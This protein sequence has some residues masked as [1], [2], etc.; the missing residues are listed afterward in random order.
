MEESVGYKKFWYI[1]M[2]L[3]PHDKQIIL[4]TI[5][6]GN[7]LNLSQLKLTLSKT[8]HSDLKIHSFL[9]SDESKRFNFLLSMKLV[10]LLLS[11]SSNNLKKMIIWLVA[12]ELNQ[13]QSKK[14]RDV[15]YIKLK[16]YA[17]SLVAYPEDKRIS[18]FLILLTKKSKS[19][20]H[21]LQNETL[22]DKDLFIL[23]IFLKI[24]G[25]FQKC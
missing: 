7:F 25:G 11:N 14:E 3:I 17:S 16:S 24:I 10:N 15:L 1:D 5:E 18:K 6:T 9:K 4:K 2:Q 19:M 12:I 20:Q 8:F 23:K 22:S 13:C 21:L